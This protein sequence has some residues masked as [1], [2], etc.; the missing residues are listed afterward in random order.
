MKLYRNIL[1]IASL[2]FLGAC[3]KDLGNYDYKDINKI[4]IGNVLDGDHN[5]ERIYR[6]VFGDSLNI[7][8]DIQGTV[9]GTDTSNLSFA[10]VVKGDTLS[11]YKDLRRLADFGFGKMVCN[12]Y[13]T[14]RTTNA[15]LNYNF[16]LEISSDAA[17]A[18]Y[19]LTEDDEHNTVLVT[20]SALNSAM[21]FRYVR[22]VGTH[23]LGK[24][25]ASLAI[26]RNDG[27]SATN[28]TYT[29]IL[30]A[31]DASPNIVEVLTTDILPILFYGP[32]QFVETPEVNKITWHYHSLRTT[33]AYI[34]NNGKVHFVKK[35]AISSVLYRNDPLDY[36]FGESGLFTNGSLYSRYIAGWDYKNKRMRIFSTTGVA[37]NDLYTTN[38]DH[39]I[40][41]SL[42]EGHDYLMGVETFYS[43][44]YKFAMLTKKGDSLYSHEA[45]LP[46]Y[47]AV[48]SYGRVA[49]AKV[50]GLD[51]M[52]ATPVYHGGAHFWYF[53]IGR[54]IY[55]TSLL[56]LDLQPVVTLPND[57]SGDIVTFNFNYDQANNFTKIGIATYNPAS[58]QDLKGSYY[59]Y[60]IASNTIEASYLNV[61]HKAKKIEIGL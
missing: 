30:T 8:P 34:L 15:V 56:G 4:T 5:S 12:Y 40:D 50:E 48:S 24:N 7:I 45:V 33:T 20:K 38:W 1:T 60:D 21:P 35:G 46:A 9:S 51:R 10:W 31:K 26:R 13:V 54:T 47:T 42:T 49:A 44:P 25:P 41:P 14:D 29:I 53:G 11:R 28:Y 17:R 36:D 43:S 55:R 59:V 22:T 57:G 19:I 27:S 18:H 23:S 52:E 6:V 37:A 61:L 3:S 39:I 16:T 2:A 32:E 58:G